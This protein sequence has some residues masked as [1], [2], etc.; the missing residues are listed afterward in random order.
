M[1]FAG[2]TVLVSLFGLRLAGL[3]VYSSFGYATFAVVGAVMLAS[4]TLVPAL[5]GLAGRRVLRA[6]RAPRAARRAAA[7]TGRRRRTERWAARRRR[8]GRSPSA[9]AALVVL[10]VLAAPVLG[11]RTWPQ[12]AGSQPTSNTTRLA[13]DL[14]AAEYGP[15]ANGPFAGGRRPDAR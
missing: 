13:Y 1:V 14:V 11:M 15:G 6:P 9:L 10:L 8:A 7:A 5:C 2:S 4:V 3:P 12:D